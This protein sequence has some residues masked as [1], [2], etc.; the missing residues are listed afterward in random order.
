MTAI[1]LLLF[2][3]CKKQVQPETIAPEPVPIQ[4]EISLEKD[5]EDMEDVEVDSVED[6]T[7]TQLTANFNRIHFDVDSYKLNEASKE[8]LSEN[9]KILDTDRSIKLEIQGH[10][11]ERGT[12]GYNLT[13]GHQ[14]LNLFM[15][16]SSIMG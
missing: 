4:H 8:A 1:A 13:L 12:T 2:S 3:A 6:E 15:I 16:S 14:K 5:V 11:D 10:A 7:V 9:I